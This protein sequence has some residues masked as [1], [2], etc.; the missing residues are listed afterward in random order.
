MAKGNPERTRERV[1]QW[2]ADNQEKVKAY[3]REHYQR[4]KHKQREQE[5]LRKAADPEKHKARVRGYELRYNYGISLNTYNR[6]AA[7]QGDRCRICLKETKL[8]VDHR[9]SDQRVRGL[10]CHKCNQG[11]GIFEEDCQRLE[12][13]IT[14]L[15]CEPPTIPSDEVSPVLLPRKRR[16]SWDLAFNKI[17]EQGGEAKSELAKIRHG[18]R[19]LLEDGNYLEAGP[20][21]LNRQHVYLVSPR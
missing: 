7:E 17:R 20:R 9:H 19:F 12:R 2:K 11:L 4:T 10:L 5:R 14:Y 13:A 6:L 1:A 16:V 8:H 15:Q 3:A 18:G 21:N